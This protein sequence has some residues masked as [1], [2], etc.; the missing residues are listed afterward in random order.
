MNVLFRVDGG[1]DVGMGHIVRSHAL[2]GCLAERGARVRFLTT[3]GPGRDWLVSQG[4]DAVA[5]E[6][7]PGT[8]ADAEQAIRCARDGGG[9]VIVTDGYR[10]RAEYLSALTATGLPV[11]SIDD[12]AAWPFPSDLIVNG[13]FGSAKLRYQARSRAIVLQGP[14]YLL[15]R[16]PFQPGRA[17]RVFPPVVGRMLACFGGA[18]PLDWTGLVLGI[19]A[20][21]SPRPALDLVVGPAYAR[22]EALRARAAIQGAVVS[23]D[24]TAG[25]LAERMAASDLAVASCGMV[26]AELMALGVPSLLGVMSEDQRGNAATLRAKRAA[27]VVEP[28]DTVGVRAAVTDLLV[29]REARA[30]LSRSAGALVDG[31]GCERVAEAV[32][33]LGKA[34]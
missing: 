5:L 25:A 16:R 32:L 11:A 27:W 28:F 20:G 3:A 13:G 23:H 6:A 14:Q 29:D 7:A 34:A 1:E 12:L 24:L 9:G 19:W 8:P 33:S 22:L 15:L 2:A 21:L 30:D 4:I 17:D 18:D 31:R 26:A 10:F